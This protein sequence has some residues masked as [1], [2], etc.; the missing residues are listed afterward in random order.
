MKLLANNPGSVLLS[1]FVPGQFW[2]WF[3]SDLF[4]CKVYLHASVPDNVILKQQQQST[5]ECAVLGIK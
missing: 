5:L 1:I 3:S 4:N 2:S